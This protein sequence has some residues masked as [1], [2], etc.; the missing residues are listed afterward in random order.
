MSWSAN[1]DML[2]GI[3]LLLSQAQNP[4]AQVQQAIQQ[5]RNGI[6]SF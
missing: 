6:G 3:L 2:K 1:G 5:V 4:Q